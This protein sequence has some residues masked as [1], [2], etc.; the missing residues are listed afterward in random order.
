MSVE[1]SN[2]ID[3]LQEKEDNDF[4]KHGMFWE[5][6]GQRVDHTLKRGIEIR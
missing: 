3:F 5:Y 4:Q 2:V 6:V 1:D